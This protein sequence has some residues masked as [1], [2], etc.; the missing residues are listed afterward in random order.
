MNARVTKDDVDYAKGPR[1]GDFGN[2]VLYS[3]CEN[4]P[5][6]GCADVIIAKVWLIGRA[7]AAAIERRKNAE[8][9]SDDFY[10][11]TVA[12]KM[13]ES[14]IDQWLAS[15][16]VQ[17]ADSWRELGQVVAVHKQLTGLFLKMTGLEKRSLAS[18]YL[19]FHRP[20][21]F[22]IYDTRAKG[23]VAKAKVAQSIKCIATI[24]CENADAEYL[25]F[26][27]HCQWLTCDIEQRFGE[28]LAPRQIDKILLRIA[29]RTRK[30]L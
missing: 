23:A 2:G 9:T 4:H 16:P 5:K 22:F 30:R 27:R 19:H 7:Y 15:L 21:L 12:T 11:V 8:D 25:T 3:L 28:H 13:K 29:D 20:D 24:E 14:K 10:E 18:K 6:H 1:L 26:V 17:L